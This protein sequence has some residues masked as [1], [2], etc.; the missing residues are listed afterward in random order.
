MGPHGYAH[1]ALLGTCGAMRGVAID[2][3]PNW[4]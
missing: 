1:T 4:R 3:S 2:R